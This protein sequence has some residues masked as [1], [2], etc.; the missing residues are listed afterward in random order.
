MAE[1]NQ[2]KS[3]RLILRTVL[4]LLVII[5]VYFVGKYLLSPVKQT[6]IELYIETDALTISTAKSQYRQVLLSNIHLEQFASSGISKATLNSK[7]F[8]DLGISEKQLDRLD[9]KLNSDTGLLRIQE[10]P[11]LEGS[12]ISITKG[13]SP[14][15]YKLIINSIPTVLDMDVMGDVVVVG[16]P[17]RG[18]PTKTNIN[19]VEAKKASFELKNNII[20]NFTLS[21]IMSEISSEPVRI[22]GLDFFIRNRGPNAETQGQAFTSKVKAGELYL[23][24]LDGRKVIIRKGEELKF[25][26]LD[27]MLRTIEFNNNHLAIRFTGSVRGMYIGSKERGQIRSLMPSRIETMHANRKWALLIGA[28]VSLFMVIVAAIEIREK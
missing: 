9:I 14:R 11:L 22:N 2:Y 25:G 7:S 24:D 16:Q 10:L 18:R 28:A 4:F 13:D 12:T 5:S 15:D 6:F 27:G 26:K 19:I 17:L 21:P 1:S 23:E 20:L 3:R 8:S